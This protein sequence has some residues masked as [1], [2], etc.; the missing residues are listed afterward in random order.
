M[1]H[2]QEGFE[3]PQEAMHNSHVP[4]GAVAITGLRRPEWLPVEHA[5]IYDDISE[6]F[7]TSYSATNS[8]V[9]E[10]NSMR[11]EGEQ[12][13]TLDK[14][15]YEEAATSKLR[16]W[17]ENGSLDWAIAHEKE[18]GGR[19]VLVGTPNAPVTGDEFYKL[20]RNFHVNH[21]VTSFVDA[22]KDS[23]EGRPA[24]DI[25]GKP[26]SDEA[27]GFSLM[28]T[29]LSLPKMTSTSEWGG[30][31]VE[32]L[33]SKLADLQ[34]GQPNLSDPT[35]LETW[36]YFQTLLESGEQLTGNQVEAMTTTTH[37]SMP[38][39][40]KR[41]QVLNSQIYEIGRAEVTSLGVDYVGRLRT[42]LH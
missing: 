15:E 9:T 23:Y 34:E 39:A 1:T 18:L 4:I 21:Y 37:I 11:G 26:Q 27:V 41:G 8:I 30:R 22:D 32:K 5:E 25:S 29:T 20:G 12:I 40:G 6:Q 14:A 28:P 31:T 36:T 42:S 35:P 38:L 17:S 19:M 7:E 33:R 16:E 10:I 24:E 2:S 13:A 3:Q